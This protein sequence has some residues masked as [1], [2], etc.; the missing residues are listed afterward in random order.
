MPPEPPQEAVMS[1]P[2]AAGADE[3]APQPEPVHVGSAEPPTP[4]APATPPVPP[5][6]V[7]YAPPPPA[8]PRPPRPAWLLPLLVGLAGLVLGLIIGG[9]GGALI[10][11]HHGGHGFGDQRGYYYQRGPHGGPPM[12]KRPPLKTP[13]PQPSPS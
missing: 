6:Q 1:E 11:H 9:L 2:G 7:V 10:G 13:V 3:T 5:V 8:Q 4:P 12:I